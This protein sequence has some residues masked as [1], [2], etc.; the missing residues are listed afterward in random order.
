MSV[1]P[2]ET[3]QSHTLLQ[4]QTQ[5]GQPNDKGSSHPQLQASNEEMQSMQRF[6][7]YEQDADEEEDEEEREILEAEID[8]VVKRKVPKKRTKLKGGKV[9][10][11]DN[12]PPKR[13]KQDDVG[14][15]FPQLGV[16]HDEQKRLAKIASS[17]SGLAN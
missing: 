1:A 5:L 17:I 10:K 14:S 15:L 9:K 13:I 11:V 3:Y 2:D 4:Q 8:R 7:G 6:G 12:V 16:K